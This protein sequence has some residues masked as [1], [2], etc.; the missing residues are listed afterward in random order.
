MP[1]QT[2]CSMQNST[3][4]LPSSHKI[5]LTSLILTGANPVCTIAF[6]YR[7]TAS[8]GRP[9]SAV[10]SITQTFEFWITNEIR[11]SVVGT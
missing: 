4:R 6:G 2:D 7:V 11:L 3:G 1:N 5:I 10:T 8:W 9:V